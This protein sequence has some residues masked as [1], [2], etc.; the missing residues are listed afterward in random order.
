[1][2]KPFISYDGPDENGIRA[3]VWVQTGT[4]V[5]VDVDDD[6]EANALVTVKSTNEK[7]T[8][9][10]K[11][12]LSKND[13][14]Y[15]EVLAAFETGEEIEYRVESQRKDD[16][17]RTIP[18]QQLRATM[19]Q[20][21]ENTVLIFAGINGALSSEAVTNPEEDPAP[22]G[23][24][25][26]VDA[27]ARAQVT[28]V[29]PVDRVLAELAV[30]L[31]QGADDRTINAWRT[32]A[33]NAGVNREQVEKL[34][35]SVRAATSATQG[36]PRPVF[37]AE[38]PPYMEY[39]S[40]GRQNLGNYAVAGAFAAD[41]VAYR[42]LADAAQR[43]ME[44]HNAAVQA[45]QIDAPL[46]EAPDPVN[47]AQVASLAKVLLELADRVQVG[48]YGGG[49]PNRMAAS[50]CRA[51]ELVFDAVCTRHPVPFGA[52]KQTQL[53]WMDAV[54]DECVERF[55]RLAAIA[56]Q[57]LVIE[58]PPRPQAGSYQAAPTQGSG[59]PVEVKPEPDVKQPE[60][61][62]GAS[63]PKE[64]EGGFQAPSPELL[65]RFRI[66]ANRAGFQAS[67]DSPVVAFLRHRFGVGLV[68]QV[69]AP[70]LEKCLAHYERMGPQATRAFR[71]D[72]LAAAGHTN[73]G[74][75]NQPPM[76]A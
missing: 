59:E 22:G 54:V 10:I 57:P 6:H 51:R 16:I 63:M 67:P 9:P 53:A 41:R 55:K 60:Q 7:V 61:P 27:P 74:Q 56:G 68:R 65:A 62:E 73:A 36:A 43:A 50:H 69:S 58:E 26:A 35:T 8:F 34:V 47:L 66:L 28:V 44:Q 64:A 48:A 30:A 5:I 52:D 14:I 76:A 24:I 3:E 71:Q 75:T 39:N 20:A 33:C 19:E 25:R 42:L 2:A 29:S 45:G 37:A 12:W 40:D 21:R 18:I 13:P 49:R 1:M 11:G 46:K 72:V 4:G 70:D 38:A 31:V 23:R 15:E 17:D 32:L